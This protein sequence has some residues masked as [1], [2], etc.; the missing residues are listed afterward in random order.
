MKV[1]LATLSDAREIL[2]LQKQA[3]V[4]EALLYNDFSIQPIIQSLNSIEKEFQNCWVWKIQDNKTIVASVRA[5]VDADTC[6]IGKLIVKP[7][8]QNRGL[9]KRLMQ[10]VE[11]TVSQAR[12]F[13]LFTAHKSEKNLAL[14]DKLGYRPF[15][16]RV[17]NENVTLVYMEKHAASYSE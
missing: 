12:R 15:R 6:Y 5:F 2:Y 13:E 7:S 16:Q 3:Y 8:H 17:L 10:T 14:Y 9:G 4:S 11:M 1:E